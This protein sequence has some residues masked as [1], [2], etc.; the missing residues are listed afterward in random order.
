MNQVSKIIIIIL[1]IILVISLILNLYLYVNLNIPLEFEEVYVQKNLKEN[2]AEITKQKREDKPYYYWAALTDSKFEDF[3]C[4]KDFISR[5]V[6]FNDYDY[7]NFT[8]IFTF[9]YELSEI[10]YSLNEAKN[11]KF[12]VIPSPV[13]GKVILKDDYKNNI[14][15]YKIK[16]MDITY[17]YHDVKNYVAFVKDGG[18][19][20]PHN[21]KYRKV[22]TSKTQQ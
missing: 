7:K 22:T 2:L 8:Y 21:H 3:F 4:G 18:S 19:Y 17:D 11:H 10:S 5:N 12:I 20:N 13:I 14:Y 6:E 1:S 9:G 15:I 16:K